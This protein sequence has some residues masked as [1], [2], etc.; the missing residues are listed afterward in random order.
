M[1]TKLLSL[2]LVLAAAFLAFSS[3]QREITYQE[4]LKSL[5]TQRQ[6]FHTSL[7]KCPTVT[8]QAPGEVLLDAINKLPWSGGCV[9]LYPSTGSQV[10]VVEVF[11]QS[12]E[13]YLVAEVGEGY[14]G[15][16]Q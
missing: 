1:R 14:W 3:Y 9:V 12:F 2:A 16:V 13:G 4:T 5:Y 8:F 15:E 10:D 7:T 6:Y 11:P